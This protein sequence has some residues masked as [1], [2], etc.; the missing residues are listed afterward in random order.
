MTLYTKS[1]KFNKSNY[2]RGLI[3]LNVFFVFA[4]FCLI[5]LHLVQVNSLVSYS[6]EIRD[7]TR[8]FND[9]KEKNQDLE[10]EVTQLQSPINLEEI[11]QSFN[12]VETDIIVYLGRDKVV[13]VNE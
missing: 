1:K 3:L 13:A 4:V 5:V 10:I 2:N 11:V 12:M 9:L 6:Y 7:N 8:Y